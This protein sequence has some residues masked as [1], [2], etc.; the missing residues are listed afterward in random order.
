[1]NTVYRIVVGVDG[2]DAG[3]RALEWAAEECP[4]RNGVVQAVIAWHPEHLL[5]NV[6]ISAE[7][8]DAQRFAHE[9]V[10]EAVA[11]ARRAHPGL[12]ITGVVE[13]GRP[14]TVLVGRAE[15][16]QLLVL[17]SHGHSRLFHAALGSTADAVVRTAPC[18]VVIV[19]AVRPAE[20]RTA[21]VDQTA[22]VPTGIL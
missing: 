21:I 8:A 2:S 20:H 9:I 6:V 4:H 22:G 15:E 1:M 16:A 12:L 14:A 17:G 18:P 3:Q 13:R 5:D 11:A 7:N 19:P 10:A